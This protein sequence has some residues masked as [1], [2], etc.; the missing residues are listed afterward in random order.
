[1]SVP[2]PRPQVTQV[3]CVIERQPLG[4]LDAG[5]GIVEYVGSEIHSAG[6]KWSHKMGDSQLAVLVLKLH[7]NVQIFRRIPVREFM[8]KEVEVTDHENQS[9]TN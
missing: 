8:V 4:Q 6:E 7:H 9:S 1:M 5:M 3:V 2:N